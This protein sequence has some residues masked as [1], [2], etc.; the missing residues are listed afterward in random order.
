MISD[1]NNICI[2]F[3]TE[4][5]LYAGKELPDE[6]IKFWNE[7]LQNCSSCKRLISEIESV[8]RISKEELTDDILDAK[9]D[10]MIDNAVKRGRSKFF[11]WLFPAGNEKGKLS[12]ALKIAVVSG[13]T[14]LA[15]VV[16]LITNRPNPVKTVSNDLLDWEGKKVDMQISDVKTKLDVMS[17][18]D[19]DKQIMLLD[20]RIKKLEKESD[21]FSFN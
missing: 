13:L 15:I 2:E 21:K 5:F 16:S 14:V 1:G 10:C 12:V 20:K 3:E 19:W 17:E 4:A 18:D 9:F 8:S 7:H 6:K 11:E